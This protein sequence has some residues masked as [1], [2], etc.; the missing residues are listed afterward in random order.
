MTN[1]TVRPIMTVE[2][3][4]ALNKFHESTGLESR[5][6]SIIKMKVKADDHE[7]ASKEVIRL[8]GECFSLS[9]GQGRIKGKLTKAKKEAQ[10]WKLIAWSMTAACVALIATMM[11][12]A[13]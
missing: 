13:S 8:S 10:Q 1:K 5:S 7:F 2:A 9:V 3:R 4:D 11:L 12:A 6:D